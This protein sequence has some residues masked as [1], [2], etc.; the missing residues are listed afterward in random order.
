MSGWLLGYQGNQ[1]KGMPFIAPLISYI[2]EMCVCVC[3]CVHVH[4]H[5]DVSVVS[6]SVRSYGLQPGR[7][8]CPLDSPG[9]NAGVGCHALLWG[10][11]QHWDRT[12]VS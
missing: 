8:L 6:N 12:R 11:S 4:T 10:S 1:L 7:L 3:V 9:K 2:V 5:F